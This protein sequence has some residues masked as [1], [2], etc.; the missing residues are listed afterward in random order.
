[1]LHHGGKDS[2]EAGSAHVCVQDDRESD[3]HIGD[4]D[5]RVEY[6]RNVWFRFI[7][8]RFPVLRHERAINPAPGAPAGAFV[9]VLRCNTSFWNHQRYFHDGNG[10]VA[11]FKM[12]K[13]A[14]GVGHH[15]GTIQL[16]GG[17][18]PQQETFLILIALVLQERE[19]ERR[20]LYE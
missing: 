6:P 19:D 12:E 16:R 18:T 5:A 14:Y 3:V 17:L 13:K 4:L 10:I 9:P 1:M 15:V 11:R 7:R 8:R 2:P 20:K